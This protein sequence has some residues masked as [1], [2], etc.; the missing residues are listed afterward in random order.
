MINQQFAYVAAGLKASYEEHMDSN[1]RQIKEYLERN[2]RNLSEQSE[3]IIITQRLLRHEMGQC[4]LMYRTSESEAQAAHVEL[5][6]HQQATA[7]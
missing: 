1:N 6:E 4:T 3:R 5:A 7:Y 2:A